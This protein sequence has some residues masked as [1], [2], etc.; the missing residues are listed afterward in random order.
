MN[1]MGFSD[2]I[3]SK[4]IA[5]CFIDAKPYPFL[6]SDLRAVTGCGSLYILDRL[7]ILSVAFIFGLLHFIT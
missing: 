6:H 7:E 3:P 1:I 2:P 4:L 5:K